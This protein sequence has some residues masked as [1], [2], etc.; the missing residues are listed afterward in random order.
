MDPYLESPAHWSDFHDRFI[1]TLCETIADTLPDE[2]FARIC[3]DVVLLEPDD[4]RFQMQP[5]VLVGSDSPS[6]VSGGT[7]RG[8]ATLE[9]TTLANVIPL[10]PR[11]ERAI[12]V[13]RLPDAE[14]V[15]AVEVLSPTNKHGDGR[16]IYTEKRNRILRGREVSLVEID[17]LRA[18][19]RI[20]LAKPLPVGHYYALVSRADRRP[21]CD[22]Y[23]WTVRDPL[24]AIPIPLRAPH[25]DAAADLAKAFATAYERGR[26]ARMVRYAGPPA[27]P[28]LSA[29]DAAWA[30]SIAN[31][32][33]R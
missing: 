13:I 2:Y 12:E 9:P 8:A 25:P 27:A 14:V 4:I 11:T 16:G 22:V 31:T 21:D 17:L 30:A 5:D 23:A 29:D 6:H 32:P 28:A 33:V 7:G 20:Q 26:Y 3:E 19:R 10:D 15:T 1:N 18:G 24:P